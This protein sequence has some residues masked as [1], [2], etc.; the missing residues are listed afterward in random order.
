MEP[1]ATYYSSDFSD[2]DDYIDCL[3]QPEMVKEASF[4]D[5]VH[6]IGLLISYLEFCEE[7]KCRGYARYLSDDGHMDR[8]ILLGGRYRNEIEKFVIGYI[9]YLKNSSASD[10]D[11]NVLRAMYAIKIS[12]ETEGWKKLMKKFGFKEMRTQILMSFLQ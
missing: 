7:T 2:Y 6:F 3:L 8:D 10:D 1:A 12:E 4:G 9:S 5:R 11:K